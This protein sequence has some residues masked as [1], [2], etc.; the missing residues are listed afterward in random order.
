M[1]NI[2]VVALSWALLGSGFHRSLQI[3]G[4]LA[5][6]DAPDIAIARPYSLTLTLPV[7]AAY[8]FDISEQFKD[9]NNNGDLIKMWSD[10][11]IDLELPQH[12]VKKMYTVKL[13]GTVNASQSGCRFSWNLPVHF[14]YPAPMPRALTSGDET[15]SQ[16]FLPVKTVHLN[17]EELLVGEDRSV[18]NERAALLM[19]GRLCAPV[20]VGDPTFGKTVRHVTLG[21]VTLVALGLIVLFS[22]FPRKPALAFE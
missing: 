21:T 7:H 5:G 17:D 6:F 18:S 9:N 22:L 11:P 1:S 16:C 13:T 12:R 4:T 2:F 14:R 3:N 10:E 15:V 8:Y 20:P 19:L